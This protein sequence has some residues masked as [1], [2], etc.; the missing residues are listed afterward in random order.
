MSEAK[1]HQFLKLARKRSLENGILNISTHEHI[2]KKT[3]C[4]NLMY[5]MVACHDPSF[6]NTGLLLP[7]V[8]VRHFDFG[9][10]VPSTLFR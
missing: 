4:T 8:F 9:K 3:T 6:W 2:N 1:Q 7:G 10:I 5:F